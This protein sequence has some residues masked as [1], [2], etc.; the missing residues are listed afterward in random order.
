M[1]VWYV[2][3][4]YAYANT[5][6]YCADK[7]CRSTLLA[8]S[9]PSTTADTRKFIPGT[10]QSTYNV[11]G[12]SFTTGAW[13]CWSPPRYHSALERGTPAAL[14]DRTGWC[15]SP[16]VKRKRCRTAVLNEAHGQLAIDGCPLRTAAQRSRSV[17]ITILVCK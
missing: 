12:R 2:C 4:E 9:H 17:S 3:F 7:Y 10:S 8:A 5:Q 6:C 14:P 13:W 15:V 11:D 16:L 1:K